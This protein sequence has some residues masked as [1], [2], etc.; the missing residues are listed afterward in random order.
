PEA[1]RPTF[2]LAAVL[3]NIGEYLD[4]GATF[5]TV[6]SIAAW[7][8]ARQGMTLTA[9][10][11]RTIR[12]GIT[13]FVAMYA[14]TIFVPVRSSLYAVAPSIRSALVAGAVA[15]GAWRAAPGMAAQRASRRA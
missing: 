6:A 12:I 1:S 2:T 5:A 11:R 10:E 15:A 4:R 7:L 13:W 3:K 9:D 14:I 8:A